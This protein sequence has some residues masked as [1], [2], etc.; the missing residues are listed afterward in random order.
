[1]PRSPPVDDLFGT[2]R[3][4]LINSNSRRNWWSRPV[5]RGWSGPVALTEN[6]RDEPAIA[7][8]SDDEGEPGEGRREPFFRVGIRAEFV[9][10]AAHV[11]DEGVSGADRS[12]RA[13]LFE[14]AHRPRSSLES[15][16]ICFD[17]VMRL[18]RGDQKDHLLH[19]CGGK[20]QPPLP[21][22]PPGPRTPPDRPS[23]L[24]CLYLVTV[25]RTPPGVAKSIG[26]W[27][28]TSTERFA[29]T[30]EGLIPPVAPTDNYR[31]N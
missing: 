25:P 27:A 23:R 26:R 22:S 15:P 29:I 13:Q 10:A 20:P 19:Q 16:M 5:P 7:S 6:G 9:V 3:L 8:S 30:F 31:R 24:K 21:A 28:G 1:M 14:A 12:G 4:K 18:R 2:H 11:L 17:K